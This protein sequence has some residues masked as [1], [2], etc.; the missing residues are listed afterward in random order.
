MSRYCSWLA[1]VFSCP[2]FLTGHLLQ[3]KAL[4]VLV[5]IKVYQTSAPTGFSLG[6]WS[7]S[8]L[9]CALLPPKDEGRGEGACSQG[10]KRDQPSW[11]ERP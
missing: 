10:K 5:G 3:H 6:A 8:L 1:G 11:I 7:L 2:V 9:P 4:G